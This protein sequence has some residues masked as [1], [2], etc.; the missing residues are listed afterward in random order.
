V[1][2]GAIFYG[3]GRFVQVKVNKKASQAAVPEEQ[4]ATAVA[5]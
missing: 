5:A 1:A 3:I 4:P 2:G